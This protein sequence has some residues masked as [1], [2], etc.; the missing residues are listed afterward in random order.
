[1]QTRYV[2][3]R[4][5]DLGL[6]ANRWQAGQKCVARRSAEIFAIFAQEFG[7]AQRDRFIGVLATQAANAGLSEERLA[8]MKDPAINPSGQ[9]PDVL[10]I[11]PYFG[12]NYEPRM[13]LPTANRVVTSIST[14]SIAEAR[15]WTS[16]QRAV[17]AENNLRLVCYEGGQHFTGILGAENNNRLTSVLHAANR[18]LRMESRYEEYLAA[19]ANEGVD[20]FVHFNHISRWS[21]WGSWGALEHQQQPE[22]EAPKWRAIKNWA[23][24][25]NIPAP[26]PVPSVITSVKITP[27]KRTVTA[28]K[29]AKV[30]V[31][32]ANNSTQA[33]TLEVSFA[34]SNPSALPVPPSRSVPLP[35]KKNATQNA[36][37]TRVPVTLTAPASASGMSQLTATVAGTS[38]QPCEVTIKAA[39]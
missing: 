19:I 13:A 36:K 1:M 30:M 3:D 20:L 27:P 11:A 21:Q 12:V 32:I 37:V 8:A 5:Q 31:M 22:S 4:G 23:E 7:A 2:Q 29:S 16:E 10:A 17:A 9:F 39:N 15:G 34:S 38:S 35:G 18:D 33:Q 26:T 6:D 25:G 14:A 24:R 28:G